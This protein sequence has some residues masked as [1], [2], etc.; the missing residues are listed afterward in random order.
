[1]PNASLARF[2]WL[3]AVLLVTGARPAISATPSFDVHEAV[4]YVRRGDEPLKADFYVP[5]G[6]GPFPAV[7]VVHGGAW[8]AGNRARISW[9]ASQLAEQGYTAMA[10]NYRLAP[11]FTFPAQLED[12]QAALCFLSS[13]AKTYKADPERIGAFG[14][15]AGGH[16]V[17]LLGTLG[18]NDPLGRF[19]VDAGQPRPQL[20]AVAAGGAP[21][22]FCL[23]A[24]ESRRLA[25]WLGGTRAEKPDAY[26][27]ASPLRFV[28]ADDPPMFFFHGDADGLV[29]LGSAKAMVA[30]L[31]TV[32]VPA[33]LH[34]VSHQGHVAAYFDRDALRASIDFLDRHLKPDLKP[35]TTK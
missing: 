22:D 25:Y 9:Q 3:W 13:H 30:K 21:C 34:T 17:A 2:S 4:E 23:I 12:C 33:H 16:L 26:E 10:I 15:S 5:R 11:R 19:P 35:A 18:A 20:K 1:M 32:G 29:P 14:Y 24:P 8:M 7:L 28:S 27:M 6:K 31:Q